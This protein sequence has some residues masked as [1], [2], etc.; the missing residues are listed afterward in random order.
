MP[1]ALAQHRDGFRHISPTLR[2]AMAGAER[3]GA[4]PEQVSTAPDGALTRSPALTIVPRMNGLTAF[5]GNCREI[6]R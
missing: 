5:F 1:S 3:L 4:G 6:I 2:L